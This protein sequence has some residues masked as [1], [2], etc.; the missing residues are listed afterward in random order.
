MRCSGP[1]RS[2]VPPPPDPVAAQ[3]ASAARR[4][5]ADA[6]RGALARPRSPGLI[7]PGS[8][9]ASSGR[10][11]R[12]SPYCPS[13]VRRSCS[14]SP[15]SPARRGGR[16]GWWPRA[17]R[18]ARSPTSSA[19]LRP[20]YIIDRVSA[21]RLFVFQSLPIVLSVAT[22][23][24]ASGRWALPVAFALMGFGVWP[25]QA[26]HH[27]GLGGN[28]RSSPCSARS[29]A[30][31]RCMSSSSR[32][33]RRSSSA[34][35]S[36]PAS[37]VDV[38]LGCFAVAGLLCHAAARSTPR[39]RGFDLTVV[40]QPVRVAA[41]ADAEHSARFVAGHAPAVTGAVLDRPCRRA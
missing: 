38:I 20:G 7:A 5:R 4:R 18:R 28:L 25:R 12:R 31:W 9:R 22:L 37:R 32:R 35:C 34:R 3:R 13:S 40:R 19:C 21:R 29:G 16:S 26:G 30:R 15:P 36:E 24:F 23:A 8:V 39:W 27:R 6:G 11:C 14:T 1:S 10:R 33:W 2:F 41:D 17:S